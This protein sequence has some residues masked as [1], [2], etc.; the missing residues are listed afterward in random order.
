MQ[1]F[2]LFNGIILLLIL[3]KMHVIIE[4]YQFTYSIEGGSFMLQQFKVIREERKDL[5]EEA[6]PITLMGELYH[7]KADDEKVVFTLTSEAIRKMCASPIKRKLTYFCPWKN[8]QGVGVVWP[9]E[10]PMDHSDKKWMTMR[11][12]NRGKTYFVEEVK[13]DNFLYQ[14]PSE[15]SK[16]IHY[17]ID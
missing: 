7:A 10:D 16:T 8:T 12:D 11:T 17:I 15:G 6:C 9:F 3:C 1:I 4:K 2:Q 5:A 14:L 13:T